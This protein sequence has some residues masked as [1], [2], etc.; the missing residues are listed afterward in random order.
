MFA[1]SRNRINHVRESFVWWILHVPT[2]TTFILKTNVIFSCIVGLKRAQFW[3]FW[4]F[5]VL[6]LLRV[7]DA[8][9]KYY[10]FCASYSFQNIYAALSQKLVMVI[11]IRNKNFRLSVILTQPLTQW[12]PGYVLFRGWSSWS[13]VL[14]IYLHVV[15]TE[16]KLYFIKVIYY[17]FC[18]I[19]YSQH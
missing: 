12:L 3:I 6:Y 15:L 10:I 11:Y 5:L 19:I 13:V 4:I 7:G 17:F 14:T 8:G 16:G 18:F 2:V 9:A 1:R